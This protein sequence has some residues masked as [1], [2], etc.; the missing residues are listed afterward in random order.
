MASPLP[1][2]ILPPAPADE[3]A[4]IP[5]P[6]RDVFGILSSMRPGRSWLTRIENIYIGVFI[7]GIL[8]AVFWSVSKRL[9]SLFVDVAGFYHFIWGPPLI[10]LIFLGVL[11]YSTIQGFVSFTEPDCLYLLP[12]PVRRSDLVRPK[13]LSAV[14]LLGIAGAV[15]GIIA[16]V[17]SSGAHTGARIGEAALAGLAL[18]VLL[19]SVSWHVQRLRWATA[20]VMRLTL[21]LVG[22]TILL[23]FLQ[24]GGHTAKFAALWS[25]PWGWGVLPLASEAP[26]YGIAAL[27]AL[28]VLALIAATSLFRSAAGWSLEG[29]RV[30]ARTRSQIVASLYAF[31]YRSVGQ[32]TQ[33]DKPQ[34]W[35]SRLKLRAPLRPWMTVPWHG[36]NTLMRSPVRLGWGVVLAGAGMYL[37]ATQPLKQGEI[38]AGAIALYLA[39]S[40][41]LEP[42]RQEVDTPGAAKVLLPWRF[43]KVLWLHCLVPI[44]LMAVAGLLTLAVGLAAGFLTLHGAGTMLILTIPLVSVVV[45]SAALSSR[46]GGRVSTNLVEFAAMD[47]TGFS[48]I[49][50]LGQL[51]MWAVVSLAATVLATWVLGRDG[52]PFGLVF[53]A[54]FVLLSLTAVAMWRGVSSKPV[55]GLLERMADARSGNSGA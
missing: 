10:V 7:I 40:S 33:T 25:G 17:A 28:C 19:I 32:A 8:I 24:H 35:Q 46:R 52:F 12:S 36:A 39:A 53:V 55:P 49:F 5:V 54:V 6:A 14:I 4:I 29:F 41:L 20:L 47:T 21:P 27:G 42:L 22:L 45:H 9:G 13:L 11:R 15:A 34:T 43:E 38:W 16:V 37:L 3:E 23:A 50:V 51:A 44:V 31:D 48:W 26:S 1:R 18:G 30:R 2:G